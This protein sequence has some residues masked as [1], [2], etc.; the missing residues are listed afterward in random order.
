M[1]HVLRPVLILFLLALPLACVPKGPSA[2]KTK[3]GDPPP[4]TTSIN[5]GKPAAPAKAAAKGKPAA[6][7]AKAP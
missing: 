4:S 6:P 1:R 5:S 2:T 3:A 7:G